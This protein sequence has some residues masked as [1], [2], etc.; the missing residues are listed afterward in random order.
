MFCVVAT[1]FLDRTAETL[2]P[3]TAGSRVTDP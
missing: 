1:D 2:H 3:D